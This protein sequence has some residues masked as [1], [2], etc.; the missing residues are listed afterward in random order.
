M[1]RGVLDLVEEVDVPPGSFICRVSGAKKGES[2]YA[3][4]KNAAGKKVSELPGDMVLLFEVKFIPKEGDVR[5]P[6][7]KRK[8]FAEFSILSEIF[9]CDEEVYLDEL[10]F[11]ND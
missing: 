1:Q 4:N 7:K 3:L 9:T 2:S 8:S 10:D 6:I 11:D 5:Q